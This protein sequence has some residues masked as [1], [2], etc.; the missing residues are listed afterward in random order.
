MS[1]VTPTTSA[2]RANR[3]PVVLTT[4]SIV[5][6]AIHYVLLRAMA[7]GHIADL[8]LSTSNGTPPAGAT[9]LALGLVVVRFVSVMLVPGFLL[10][11]AAEVTAYVLVGPKRDGDPDDP[12][13]DVGED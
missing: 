11:A 2:L 13:A 3:R 6:L 12:L 1:E 5:C 7:H 9:A 10:A 4:I 8:L